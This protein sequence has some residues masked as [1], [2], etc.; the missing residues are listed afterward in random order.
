MRKILFIILIVLTSSCNENDDYA[1]KTLIN[2]KGRQISNE[3]NKNMQKG[4]TYLSVYS[5][6]YSETEHKVYNL[7]ATVSM[8]NTNRTDT[9]FLDNAEFFNTEGKSI[10]KYVDKTIYIAPM[11]TLEIIIEEL[12][13]EGGTGANFLFDWRISPSSTEPIFEAVMISSFGQGLSFTT[14][15]S[16]IH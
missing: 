16:K 12:D 1:S 14:H 5:Q 6:I 3:L 4:S 2:W 11:E 9:L 13:Q 8:R 15:G 7:T 10:R